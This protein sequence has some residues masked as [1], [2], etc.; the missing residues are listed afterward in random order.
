MGNITLESVR[1][2]LLSKVVRFAVNYGKEKIIIVEIGDRQRDIFED[3]KQKERLKDLFDKYSDKTLEKA[4]SGDF[5]DLIHF[6]AYHTI[7]KTGVKPK[8]EMVR[9]RKEIY[10]NIEEFNK[11]Y[12]WVEESFN[13]LKQDKEK[14]EIEK[15]EII[16][17][18]GCYV[19]KE[20]AVYLCDELIK[21]TA[22]VNSDDQIDILSP[23][24]CLYHTIY[25]K[26]FTH[27][28]GHL[29]FDWVNSKNREIKEKQA[30]YFSSYI[31]DG[32]ID[33]FI[34]EFTKNQPT[35]YHNPYLKGNNRAKNLYEDKF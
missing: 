13:T 34:K 33:E 15:I 23:Q 8:E 24:G 10:K 16:E 4:K 17:L 18:L 20:K 22:Q 2:Y 27:E 21:E 32:E 1:D 3:N 6:V 28:F 12:T 7:E 19:S 35:E 9:L 26:V 30:N 14:L 5:K 11:D 31:T 29:V 25:K